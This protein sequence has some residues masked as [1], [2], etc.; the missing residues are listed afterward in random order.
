[1]TLAS[2]T[3]LG[4]YE[5]I[6][7]I[8]A[9]GMG[10]VWRAKDTR[11]DRD[12]AIKVLPA[13]FA[14]DSQLQ[15]RFEREAKAISSLNHPHICTLHDV[16]HENGL[17]YLVME[18]IEGESLAERL[19]RG[20]L[21]I[22]QTLRYGSQIAAALDAAHRRGIVHRDLKPANIMLTKSGA[23]LLDFGLATNPLRGAQGAVSVLQT[24]KR[25]ITQE[26]TI[27]GTFQYMAPEQL[28]GLQADAR[29]DIFAL[30]AVLYEMASGKRAFQGNSKTSLIA[31]IVSAQP[32]PV[33]S[34]APLTPP[35]FD[36]LLRK[37]LEK[38]PNDRW[39][40]A[41]DIAAEL[42]WI[43]EAG[44]AAGVPSAIRVRKA[45]RLN[46]TILLAGAVL[47][48]GI[49]AAYQIFR[50]TRT[51]HPINYLAVVAPAGA[52]VRA[53]RGIAL[54]P[55]GRSVVFVAASEG[56]PSMLWLRRL[57]ARDATPL[58]GT[59]EAQ[60]PFWS[61]DGRSIG[62]F[63]QAQL[64]R[65]D[66]AGGP[67]DVICAVTAEARGGAWSADGRIVFAP[68]PLEGLSEV[69]AS[70]G[71]PRVLTKLDLAKGEKSHRW[72][73]FVPGLESVLFLVQT[74]EG[75]A[76]D[77][78]SAIVALDGAG[79]MR[80]LIDANSSFAFVKPGHILYWK[81]GSVVARAF[82]P[83]SLEVGA[84]VERVVDGVLYTNNEQAIFSAGAEGTL[85][86]VSGS[87]R[88]QQFD[89]IWMGRDGTRRSAL[90]IAADDSYVSLSPD[91]SRLAYTV[92]ADIRVRDLRR[93]T[94]MR[95]SRYQGDDYSPIWSHDGQWVFWC[96]THGV[97]MRINRRA[98]S[99]AGDPEVVFEGEWGYLTELSPDGRSIVGGDERPPAPRVVKYDFEEKLVTPLVG[100]AF[101]AWNGRYSADGQWLLFTSSESGRSEVYAQRIRGDARAQISNAGGYS[102]RWSPG[103]KEIL[104]ITREGALMS[105]A[106]EQRDGILD[107]GM[108]TEVLK[109][110]R[111]LEG[112]V[113]VLDD[114]FVVTRSSADLAAVEPIG[115]VQNWRL[116]A[117]QQR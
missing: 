52:V 18:L 86:Y 26:G 2:G 73:L 92:G 98:A 100:G 104:Y 71:Q 24:E 83:K 72:P 5:I 54:S 58:A 35:A 64:K 62:F 70:G 114:A 14:E 6:S 76:T 16:G 20:P 17:Q 105:V 88:V 65:I 56:Q 27:L 12:V 78:T 42:L 63:T 87:M 57:S 38:D 45:T 3:R 23:K 66:V 43:S 7:S 112:L 67:P 10:E 46:L 31:A 51:T 61:P 33:S 99:G 94:E 117:S 11:L 69:S 81:S 36:H 74:T 115:I 89:V 79:T 15:A 59:E 39:Q 53:D 85:A 97:K 113:A 60:Y 91:G 25:D 108:P 37:C 41:H 44:S 22:D 111:S 82:R 28:E 116:G 55:D 102:P 84:E 101:G 13:V 49:G 30:G 4:P 19:K 77:D 75:G 107:P 21:S 34:V 103:G 109:A 32:E 47:G 48:A 8:G 95:L 110:D 93:G 40:S 1:M 96:S 106:L 68:G 9:G 90:R 29:T 50:A 80:H